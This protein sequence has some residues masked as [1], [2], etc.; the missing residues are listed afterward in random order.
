MAQQK[1]N[2]SGQ[3]V[4]IVPCRA[5]SYAIA[6]NARWPC[7]K[8]TSTTT[9]LTVGIYVKYID[10]DF[11]NGF[12]QSCVMAQTAPNHRKNSRGASDNGRPALLSPENQV[13]VIHL[14][15]TDE[16]S[17]EIVAHRFGVSKPTIARIRSAYYEK[18]DARKLTNGDPRR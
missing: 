17:V 9:M 16:L 12:A 6:P 2:S 14:L 3:R 5:S 18:M 13:R 10:I 11:R 15:F 8:S 7:A 1:L 4:L